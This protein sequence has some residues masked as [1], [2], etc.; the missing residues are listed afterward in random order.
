MPTTVVAVECGEP[1]ARVTMSAGAGTV[2]VPRLIGRTEDSAEVALVAGGALLLGGD[3]LDVAIRVGEGCTLELTEVGG[4]VAYAADDVESWWTVD[5]ELAR[6]S[7]L[8]WQGREL[9][10]ADGAVTR[11]RLSVSMAE[12]ARALIRETTVL[13][14]SGECGG[15]IDLVT[16]V[17]RDGFPVLVEELSARGDRPVPGVLGEHRVIDSVLLAGARPAE[18]GDALELA[19]PG[20]LARWLGTELHHSPLEATWSAWSADL[21]AK[22]PSR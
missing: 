15:T 11:R 13:G 21:P 6:D 2:L 9:V 10:V 3:R 19:E 5:V 17:V 18:P 8:L 4:T 16:T 14:R 1:R 20:A 22:L 12:G 7:T